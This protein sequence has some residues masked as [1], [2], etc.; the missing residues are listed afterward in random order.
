M[1]INNSDLRKIYRAY[2][3]DRI[4]LSREKCPSPEKLF[5]SFM[6]LGSSHKIGKIIDHITICAYCAQEFN[7][8]LEIFREEQRLVEEID[9]LL[10]Q[11]DR[12]RISQKK[13]TEFPIF[14]WPKIYRLHASWKYAI[15]PLLTIIFVALMISVTNRLII[16]KKNEERSELPG[17]IQLLGPTYEKAAQ[18]PLIFKWKGVKN[19]NYYILEIFDKALLLVWKSPRIFENSYRLPSDIGGKIEKNKNYFWMITVFLVDG[20]TIESSLEE[21]TLIE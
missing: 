1:K 2:V 7:F 9:R 10:Q 18:V 14:R 20:M 8:F 11:K 19:S 21:F 13:R 15:I 5:S 6:S 3:Q 4:P 12:A 17:Q 16:T